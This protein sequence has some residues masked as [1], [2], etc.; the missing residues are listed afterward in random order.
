[1]KKRHL[2]IDGFVLKIIGLLTMT[3]SHIG[4]IMIAFGFFSE[5]TAGYDAGIVLQYIGR[6]AFPI[7]AFLLA[8]G[9]RHTKDRSNYLLRLAIICAICAGGSAIIYMLKPDLGANIDGNAFIDLLC[10]A[11]FIYLI[12]KKK[13]R[14]QILAI[15]PL[16]YVILCY[17]MGV[18]EAYAASNSLISTWSSSY[19]SFLR[20]A[21][22]LYGFLTFLACYYA[23][24]LT[25]WATKKAAGSEELYESLDKK[26]VLGASNAVAAT[27]II[28]VNLLFWALA[29]FSLP[30][31]Y[32]M[33]AQSYA[34]LGALPI[35]FY[36]GQRG[37]NAKWWKLFGYVYYP[38]HIVLIWLIFALI[39]GI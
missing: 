7:F 18:S 5:G 16:G 34:A 8:E 11:A 33:G 37:Y 21:Y 15:L 19:P 39:Y 20:A 1:M 25:E 12:E 32:L 38:V 27:G 36:N 24:P 26:T 31:P 35:I 4:L 3:L 22:N 10:C 30:D 29:K 6:V 13:K 9:L 2:F 28:L 23:K 14:L 17:A